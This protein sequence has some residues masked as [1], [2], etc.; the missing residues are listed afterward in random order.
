MILDLSA[1]QYCVMGLILN[2]LFYYSHI[3][4]LFERKQY[5]GSPHNGGEH[6]FR[7]TASPE[8]C[9]A[10]LELIQTEISDE[11]VIQDLIQQ[12]KE[13]PY[14]PGIFWKAQFRSDNNTR[15]EYKFDD[16]GMW[17]AYLTPKKK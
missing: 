16:E 12:I 5:T 6:S 11:P 2:K 4:E 3:L 17:R 7:L 14:R 13:N 15:R 1:N 8:E 9:I 10:F